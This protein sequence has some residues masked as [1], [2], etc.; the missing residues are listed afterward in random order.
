MW[1]SDDDDDERKIISF[2]SLI[3]NFYRNYTVSSRKD[4]DIKSFD[5]NS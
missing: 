1:Q 3:F 4:L 5:R 2:A